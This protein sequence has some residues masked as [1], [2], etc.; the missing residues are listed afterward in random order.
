[1]LD[2]KLQL[3]SERST[4]AVGL[5]AAYPLTDMWRLLATLY[6]TLPI[7]WLGQNEPVGWGLTLLIV[8]SW[9]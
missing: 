9:T 1:M 4:T 8:R 3:H 7:R 6:D 2:G 5:A